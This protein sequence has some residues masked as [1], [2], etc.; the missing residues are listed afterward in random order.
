MLLVTLVDLGQQR[1]GIGLEDAVATGNGSQCQE[2]QI[3][4][5]MI[6]AGG[7]SH[8]DIAEHEDNGA[9]GNGTLGPQD[10]V[11][12]I[13]ADGYVAIHHGRESAEHDKGLSIIHVQGLHEE[14]GEDRLKAIIAEALPELNEEQ[15]VECFLPVDRMCI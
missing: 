11:T 8:H 3:L 4:L 12:K 1:G 9:Q 10:L 5:H 6:A 7:K 14:H 2:Y 15:H 13:A